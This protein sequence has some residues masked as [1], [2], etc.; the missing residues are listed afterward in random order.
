V[1]GTRL[2]G[3]A[4]QANE[5]LWAGLGMKENTDCQDGGEGG[6]GSFV[7]EMRGMDAVDR[8][9]GVKRFLRGVW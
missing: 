5:R 9:G 8:E 2:C 1:E 4:G 7:D 3:L 6:A